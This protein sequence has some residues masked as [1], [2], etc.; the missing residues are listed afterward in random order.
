[1]LFKKDRDG[2]VHK[3]YAAMDGKTVIPVQYEEITPEERGNGYLVRNGKAFGIIG[4]DGEV[5]LPAEFDNILLDDQRDYLS[6]VT[7]SMPVAARKAGIWRYYSA[8]GTPLPVQL[9]AT[10]NFD[11]PYEGGSEEKDA[12]NLSSSLLPHEE[13]RVVDGPIR[14]K[15]SSGQGH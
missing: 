1:V 9:K 13:G 2:K 14:V 10:I 8:A 5:I 11:P 6:N 15:D 12:G 3:G 7:F 4:R